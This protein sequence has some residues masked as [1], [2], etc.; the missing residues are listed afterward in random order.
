MIECLETEVPLVVGYAEGIPTSDQ[1]RVC[2]NILFI[3][4]HSI[5]EFYIYSYLDLYTT[6][7][8]MGIHHPTLTKLDAGR[9]D[10][11]ACR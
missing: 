2:P 1:L 10:A 8:D 3:P 11:L 5:S 9:Y 6:Y 4:T 7:L